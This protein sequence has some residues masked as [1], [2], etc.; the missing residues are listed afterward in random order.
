[1]TALPARGAAVPGLE[2][3]LNI[4][5]LFRRT[6]PS[7][8]PP[9]IARE[10]AIPRSTVHRLVQT[11]EGMGFLRRLDHGGA[12][13]LGPAVLT[14]GF[15]YL[16]SLDIV[17]LSDPVLAQLRDSTNCSTHLA[18][19]NG[20]DVVYLSRH[21][22][23]GAVTS[24]VGV[25][26]ALPAHG[27]VIGRMILADLAPEELRALYGDTPLPRFT[28]QTPQT[29]AALEA[30]LAED[31]KR[32]YGISASFFERGVTS[33]AAPIRDHTGRVVAAINA[34]AVDPTLDAQ[35]L[36]GR[37]KNEVCAAAV[38]ISA[39]LGARAAPRQR[40]GT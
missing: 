2:R 26:S 27:T 19:R 17:Q 37:L 3:G 9:E 24:N 29:L 28:E 12:Y 23:R 18:V 15:D 1:M 35:F 22:T 31:R 21:A 6:R 16:G 36:H 38:A 10:L 7:I 34:V 39:M 33:V 30:L 14:I 20:G 25:G 40:F 11:L 13:A 8:S 4:L 5:R 32:D